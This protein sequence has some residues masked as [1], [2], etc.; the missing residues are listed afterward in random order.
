MMSWLHTIHFLL[1]S[2]IFY[3]EC[4]FF[5]S[6][7]LILHRMCVCSSLKAFSCWFLFRDVFLFNILILWNLFYL[8]RIVFRSF[9]VS[10]SF[11]SGRLPNFRYFR[12]L[13]FPQSHRCHHDP[14]VC[15]CDFVCSKIVYTCRRQQYFKHTKCYFLSC[16]RSFALFK[17]D[18]VQ[19]A[20]NVWPGGRAVIMTCVRAFVM[21]F[22]MRFK[23]PLSVFGFCQPL[24]KIYSFDKLLMK[25][26]SSVAKF[27]KKKKKNK[28]IN[29]DKNVAEQHDG[30]LFVIK[31]QIFILFQHFLPE[32]NK[33]N[34]NRQYRTFFCVRA[35]DNTTQSLNI[36]RR[37][38]NWIKKCKAITV[39]G[40]RYRCFTISSRF[41]ISRNMS[42]VKSNQYSWKN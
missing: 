19:K 35:F 2:F 28:N 33:W 9:A 10:L 22:S 4:G 23:L 31:P 24:P 29:R 12:I 14:S 32:K 16:V 3:F 26:R 5:F 21:L 30:N 6:L 18:Y 20:S 1:L 11:Y 25:N 7:V 13:W 34:E 15:V 39:I 8:R 36:S 41:Y 27:A 37:V 17:R 42:A 40:L 38:R